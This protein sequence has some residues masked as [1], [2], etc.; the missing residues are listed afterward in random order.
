MYLDNVTVL[1][2][3]WLFGFSL[4]MMPVGAQSAASTSSASSS[5]D[6]QFNSFINKIFTSY[7]RVKLAGDFQ[8]YQLQRVSSPEP[9]EVL[10]SSS[11]PSTALGA[12]VERDG[13]KISMFQGSA[14]DL[15]KTIKFIASEFNGPVTASCLGTDK[16]GQPALYLGGEFQRKSW[17]HC[18]IIFG[19]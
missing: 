2:K 10:E 14:E 3:F 4:F 13:T 8:A 19:E 17:S 16:D 15:E 5:S 6:T 7:D 1:A 9:S 18:F 12:T 11:P